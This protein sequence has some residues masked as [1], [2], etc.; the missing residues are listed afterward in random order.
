M[1]SFLQNILNIR[2]SKRFRKSLN[3]R[4]RIVKEILMN[5]QMSYLKKK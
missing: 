3:N 2:E 1:S 5:L 4:R